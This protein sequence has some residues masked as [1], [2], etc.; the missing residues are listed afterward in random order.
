M[1][2]NK[3]YPDVN[4]LDTF[5]LVK[6]MS[7]PNKA[8]E[9]WAKYEDARAV[10]EAQKAELSAAWAEL[11]KKQMELAQLAGEF[12]KDTEDFARAKVQ[13]EAQVKQDN[14]AKA[15]WEILKKDSEAAQNG[16]ANGLQALK[17]ELQKKEWELTNRK[18]GLDELQSNL[19]RKYN[20]QVAA[21]E[22]REAAVAAREAKAKQLADL[23][24]GL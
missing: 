5:S 15:Q 11:K 21:L 24:K 17:D 13:W 14:L 3:I 7:D 16:K 4:A 22:Q 23:M 20:E 12:A 2:F 9:Y 10:Y 1:A 19:N 8:L 6:L 18:V